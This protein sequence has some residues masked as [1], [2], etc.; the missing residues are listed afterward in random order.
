M[1]V[2]YYICVICLPKHYI[3]LNSEYFNWINLSLIPK[4]QREFMLEVRF[5]KLH[6]IIDAYAKGK[7]FNYLKI[8]RNS[9]TLVRSIN[10]NS[11][12]KIKFSIFKYRDRYEYIVK[13]LMY[14]KYSLLSHRW[15]LRDPYSIFFTTF[16]INTGPHAVKNTLAGKFTGSLRNRCRFRNRRCWEEFIFRISVRV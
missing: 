7:M 15:S 1:Y 14:K 8:P 6:N 13:Y 9:N 11:V 10:G 3:F 5:L 16:A 12:F 4:W 2:K